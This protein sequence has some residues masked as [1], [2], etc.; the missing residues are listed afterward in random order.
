[1]MKTCQS[2]EHVSNNGT[3]NVTKA[4]QTTEKENGVKQKSN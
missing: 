4:T 1:M 2:N 3:D